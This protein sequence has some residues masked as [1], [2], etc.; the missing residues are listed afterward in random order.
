MKRPPEITRILV[1][2]DHALVRDGIRALLR[3]ERAWKI[4]GE[5]SNGVE[6]LEKTK[7]LRPDLVILDIRMPKLDG[8]E[9]AR[10]IHA[11]LPDTKIVVLTMHE[12]DQMVRKVFEVGVH[13]YV[14]KSDLGSQLVKG[15]REAS[16]GKR[17]ITPKVSEILLNGSSETE[18]GMTGNR[19]V[20]ASAPKLTPRELEVTRLLAEGLGNKE[21]ASILRMAV[22]T[23]ETHRANIM[24]K[25]GLHSAAA[26]VRYAL[27]EGI[28]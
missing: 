25:L 15:V 14:L 27:R 23:V 1:A 5:A 9:A 13:G 21:I 18:E 20:P 16:R 19:P 10:Q 6:A 11:A 22:R 7:R 17:Y 2:D 12:S 8:L 28:C 26:L 24:C 4:V 3:K